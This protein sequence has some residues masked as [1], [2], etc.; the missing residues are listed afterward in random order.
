MAFQISDCHLQERRNATLF[1]SLCCY[2]LPLHCLEDFFNFAAIEHTLAS[3]GDPKY[4]LQS[5]LGFVKST[6]QNQSWRLLPIC[7]NGSNV[8]S[9]DNVKLGHV[10]LAASVMFRVYQS[11]TFVWV[12]YAVHYMPL[13]IVIHIRFHPICILTIAHNVCLLHTTT[14]YESILLSIWSSLTLIISVNF[15][16]FITAISSCDLRVEHLPRSSYKFS[17]SMQSIET[18]VNK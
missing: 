2:N 1:Y 8:C 17:Y 7:P 6:L 12:L 11:Q 18:V 13:S 10:H 3:Q 4:G 15:V 14:A 16:N 9:T 5:V